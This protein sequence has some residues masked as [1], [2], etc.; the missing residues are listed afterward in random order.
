MLKVNIESQCE[1]NL[2]DANYKKKSKTPPP[3]HNAT[4]VPT[5]VHTTFL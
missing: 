5:P 2:F 1:F 3:F 4:K